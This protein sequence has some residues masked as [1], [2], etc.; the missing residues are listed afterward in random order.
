MLFSIRYHDFNADDGGAGYG[1]ELDFRASHTT[2]WGQVFG[3]K[4][5]FYCADGFAADTHK[6]WIWTQYRF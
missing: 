4:G 3:V 1:T 6:I 5:A 2:P